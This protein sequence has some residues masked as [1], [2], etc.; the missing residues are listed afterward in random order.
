MP[1]GPRVLGGPRILRADVLNGRA[2]APPSPGGSPVG[3]RGGRVAR[4]GRGFCRGRVRG[5]RGI[6]PLDQ[7]RQLGLAAQVIVDQARQGTTGGIGRLRR[8]LRPSRGS[9]R[10]GSSDPGVANRDQNSAIIENLTKLVTDLQ[11]RLERQND[12][13]QETVKRKIEEEKAK[14]QH[15]V[16]TQINNNL[17]KFEQT[18]PEEMF[19]LK[20]SGSDI[21]RIVEV[22][23]KI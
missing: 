23:G 11:E 18:K 9:S 17:D 20:A 22:R 10:G 12:E 21:D 16:S 14:I 19:K 1:R 8:G 5:L 2:P 4:P 15:K 6:R 7:Y 13:L 3:P